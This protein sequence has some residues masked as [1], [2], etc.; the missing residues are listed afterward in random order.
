MDWQLEMA[1]HWPH[2]RCALGWETIAPDPE[3]NYHTIKVYLIILTLTLD[4]Y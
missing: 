2:D 3:H 1:F 4:I